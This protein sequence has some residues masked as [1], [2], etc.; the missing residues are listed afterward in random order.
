MD[1]AIEH[2][3][4]LYSQDESSSITC[5]SK[6]DLYPIEPINMDQGCKY[7]FIFKLIILFY[8]KGNIGM[9]IV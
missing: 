4:F 3:G 2:R 7:Y 9:K 8:L 6:N 5:R 1:I